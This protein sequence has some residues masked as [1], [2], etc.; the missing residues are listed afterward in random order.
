MNRLVGRARAEIGGPARLRVVVLLAAVLGL[1]SA[2]A[3][4]VGAMA[5]QLQTALGLSTTTVGLLSTASIG[6]GALATLPMGLLVDRVPRV[7]LLAAS[8]VAW[9]M[10]TAVSGT[11]SSYPAL[12]ASRA[13]MGV[14]VATAVPAVTSLM[15]D[16]FPAAERARVYG[17]VLC[18]ELLGVGFGFLVFGALAA[19]LS[20]R[21]G[22]WM[23]APP[24][25]ALAAALRALLPEPAR[26]GQSRLV[27]G[28]T[29]IRSAGQLAWLPD[30]APPESDDAQNES[31]DRV[32]EAVAREAIRPR[33]RSGG[34]LGRCLRV[35]QP[36]QR[37]DQ[38]LDRGGVN[39]VGAS[40]TVEDLRSG[41]AG[42]AVPVVVDQ[43]QV[44]HLAAVAVLP[45]H[46]PQQVGHRIS[47]MWVRLP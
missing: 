46:L 41:G 29:T 5:P 25:L 39:L 11:V 40:E 10:A 23:L 34:G 30:P 15:G 43:L 33:I 17:F 19:A 38:P 8:I 9:S 13:A 31:A 4:S 47:G 1:Q 28:A 36:R 37:R 7:R 2:D 14:V 3:S 45:L 32:R 24:G 44:G 26:G 6:V 20:W 12:L 16:L 22:F 18:G 27:P 35:E 21:Y 42:G